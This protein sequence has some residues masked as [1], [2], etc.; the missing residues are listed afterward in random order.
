[1]N[2]DDEW[3]S[4]DD[5]GDGE[6]DVLFSYFMALNVEHALGA[7]GFNARALYYRNADIEF[8]LRLRQSR[9]RLLQMSLPLEQARHHGYYDTDES[10]R[11][12]Q[13]KKT[14]DRILERFRG[15]NEILIERR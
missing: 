10:Y 12:E 3:R 1:M 6:V 9:G 8:S 11:D 15:K 5:K 4:V 14:Y 7:S 2:V 13:S